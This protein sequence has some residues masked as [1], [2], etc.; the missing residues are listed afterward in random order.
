[1]HVYCK[2][3]RKTHIHLH[4]CISSIAL[5]STDTHTAS[6]VLLSHTHTHTTRLSTHRGTFLWPDNP[7][8]VAF[9]ASNSKA[10]QLAV[11]SQQCVRATLPAG[12]SS[13]NAPHTAGDPANLTRLTN[14]FTVC[15]CP[16]SK[17]I[18]SHASHTQKDKVVEG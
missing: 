5:P 2:C 17:S 8:R 14:P 3:T 16:K 10:L 12:S 1:M 7:W 15:L 9:P 4:I 11:L 18:S 6:S 13:G